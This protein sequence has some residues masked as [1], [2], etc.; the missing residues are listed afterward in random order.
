MTNNYPEWLR[1]TAQKIYGH[2]EQ[3]NEIRYDL[4]VEEAYE[5]MRQHPDEIDPTA[6]IDIVEHFRDE[7]IE[8]AEY[9]LEKEVE[10]L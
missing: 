3:G 5:E 2:Q 10:G 6:A 8:T 7:D 4:A 9:L 1:D